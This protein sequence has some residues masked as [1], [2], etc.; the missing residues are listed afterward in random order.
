MFAARQGF[1]YY[2]QSSPSYS[3]YI[4]LGLA[5]SPYIA[6]YGWSSGFGTK[7]SDPGTLPGNYPLGIAFS[8]V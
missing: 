8:S 5:N 6:A 1:F 2:V 3:S 7:Y 4:V